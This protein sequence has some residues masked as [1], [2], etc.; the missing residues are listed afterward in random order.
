MR[1]V[2]RAMLQAYWLV[3]RR[4][5]EEEQL[6]ESKAGYGE[7]IIKN[8]S[9]ALQKEFGKGFSLRNLQQMRLFFIEYP[10]AQTVSAQLGTQESKK[11]QTVSAELEPG[12]RKPQ[13]VS[14]VFQ[15]PDFQLSWSHY[16]VLIRIDDKAERAFY[17]IE[18]AKNNWSLRELKRQFDSGL[19]MRLALS[20]DKKAVRALAEKGNIIQSAKDL[21]KDPYILKFLNLP[22]HDRYSEDEL[23]H[24]LIDKLQ[25]FLIELGTGFTFVARQQRITIEEE[26]FHIDLVFYNRLLRCFVILDL[27]IGKLRHQ[28]IGQMQMYVNYYDRYVKTADENK[29]IGIILYRDKS[30]ALVEITLPEDNDR[31]FASRYKTI[32]PDKE[33]LRQL[34]AGK[35]DHL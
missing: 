4:I 22:E 8:L 6:G 19:Y 15:L 21:I 9:E 34:L 23:E 16:L 31:I 12:K 18:A 13:T 35:S 10:I 27:K 3:G 24:E 25:Q 33:V 17:E 11:A 14:A 30:E 20:K 5:V 7:Y 32:L 1:S 26:H 29:S 28:D 2:N